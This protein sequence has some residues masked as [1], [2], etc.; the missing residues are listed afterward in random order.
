MK[1]VMAMAA[2]VTL[3]F[4]MT[5]TPG[6]ATGDARVEQAQQALKDAG[7]DPGAIDGVMGARTTAALKAYQ[8]KQGLPVTG[9]LDDA[10]AAKLGGGHAAAAAA[11]PSSTQTGGDTKSS[12]V[13]P[14]AATTT[15]ANA[16]EGASYSRSTEKG[17]STL[18]DAEQKRK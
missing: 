2:A 10:T 17:L 12:S 6:F 18:K 14:A 1:T 11:S 15:G 8:E 16:G 7:H 4:A 9:Q 5:T 13:D 3:M